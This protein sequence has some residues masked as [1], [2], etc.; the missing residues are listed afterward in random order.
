MARVAHIATASDDNPGCAELG[1]AIKAINGLAKKSALRI[2]SMKAA[3][4]VFAGRNAR[5]DTICATRTTLA[6]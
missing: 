6:T 5:R 4:A 1:V 3:E 2:F